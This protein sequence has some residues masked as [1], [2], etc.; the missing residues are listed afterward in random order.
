MLH[1]ENHT[2][3]RRPSDGVSNLIWERLA[4][5]EDC[6]TQAFPDSNKEK[7]CIERVETEATIGS[8]NIR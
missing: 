7:G 5:D 1:M 4:T 3:T 2:A 6:N 8:A